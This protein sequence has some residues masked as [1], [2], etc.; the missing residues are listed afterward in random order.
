MITMV[1]K[2]FFGK[3]TIE[4]YKSNNVETKY[5][6]ETDKAPSGVAQ[7][8]VKRDGGNSIIIVPGANDCMT[9]ELVYLFL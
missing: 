8:T 6:F 1:G 5:V 4:N 2:D 7:I 9:P 3:S